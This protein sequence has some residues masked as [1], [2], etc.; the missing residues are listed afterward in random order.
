MT[1]NCRFF[2]RLAGVSLVTGVIILVGVACGVS[3]P[4]RS[5]Q[6]YTLHYPPPET[7]TQTPLS[8]AIHVKKIAAPSPYDT[9]HIVYADNAYRRNT[10]NYHQ[11]I[12]DP[13]E[14]LT[15]YLVRDLRAANIAKTVMTSSPPSE[16]THIIEWEINSFYEDDS[17]K[18]WQAVLELT[19]T[20]ASAGKTPRRA[21]EVIFQKT[22]RV[23]RPLSRNNPLSLARSMSA[24][25]Q[26][27]SGEIA[28]DVYTRLK[29]Q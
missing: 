9:H 18:Q 15:A 28:G 16:T 4:P 1:I 20:L 2:S 11:W 27:I 7:V 8:V 5:V 21:A 13:D 29:T 23:T 26:K 19:L 14:M 24:A 12:S 6:Y 22:Y 25:M 17:R 10:Y 3:H